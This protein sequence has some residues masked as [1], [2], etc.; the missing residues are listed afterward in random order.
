MQRYLWVVVAVLMLHQVA[1]GDDGKGLLK[2]VFKKMKS[3]PPSGSGVFMK[4]AVTVKTIE[5]TSHEDEIEVAMFDKKIKMKSEGVTIYQD[6]KTMVLI[7]PEENTIFITSPVDAD[8]RKNQLQ[9]F[10]NLQDSLFNYL[11]LKS[12]SEDASIRTFTNRPTK[13]LILHLKNEIAGGIGI[14]SVTYWL[15]EEN[16]I[17]KRAVLEFANDELQHI[18]SLLFEFSDFNYHYKTTVFNGTALA[19]VIDDRNKKLLAEYKG[20]RLIDKR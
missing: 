17:M 12:C 19:K 15:D 11:V 3:G 4:Y 14:K 9:Y 10:V 8:K 7:R 5:G 13:K 16:L 18:D 6:S 2:Q 1:L 20:Y